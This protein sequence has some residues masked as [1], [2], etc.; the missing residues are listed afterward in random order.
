[1]QQTFDKPKKI[2]KTPPSMLRSDFV[3]SDSEDV[4]DDLVYK[5]DD[6]QIIAQRNYGI[7]PMRSNFKETKKQYQNTNGFRSLSPSRKKTKYKPL[8]TTST[9][10]AVDLFSHNKRR[11]QTTTQPSKRTKTSHERTLFEEQSVG[12]QFLLFSHFS[13]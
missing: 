12:E 9:P 5:D 7:D 6:V 10:P 1:L 3:N 8:P 4:D 13:L 11:P 2:Q